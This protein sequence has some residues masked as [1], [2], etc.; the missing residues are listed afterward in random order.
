[1]KSVA[2]T[3]ALDQVKIYQLTAQILFLQE[4]PKR[5][6]IKMAKISFKLHETCFKVKKIQISESVKLGRFS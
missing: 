4:R 1:M 6:T 2:K 3:I 5:Q